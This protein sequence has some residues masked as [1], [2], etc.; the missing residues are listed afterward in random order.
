MHAA[1]GLPKCGSRR[2]ENPRWVM[3]CIRS[4][5]PLLLVPSP[6]RQ[7]SA[8]GLLRRC[9]EELLEALSRISSFPACRTKEHRHARLPAHPERILTITPSPLRPRGNCCRSDLTVWSP[10]RMVPF[11]PMERQNGR[12][13]KAWNLRQEP[14]NVLANRASVRGGRGGS[15]LISRATTAGAHTMA[16]R[17]RIVMVSVSTLTA[18]ESCLMERAGVLRWDRPFHGKR[19]AVRNLKGCLPRVILKFSARSML[20]RVPHPRNVRHEGIDRG[21]RQFDGCISTDVHSCQRPPGPSAH[22]PV[23]PL[24]RR[25]RIPTTCQSA[26]VHAIVPLATSGCTTPACV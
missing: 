17:Q 13:Y 15:N 12:S 14:I 26:A 3:R 1:A 4:P 24:L 20:P 7:I 22:E 6:A 25:L 8:G 5:A 23:D 2:G 9:A 10:L 18:S 16:R 19:E 11:R 21:L